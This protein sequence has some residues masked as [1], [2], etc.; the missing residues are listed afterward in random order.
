MLTRAEELKAEIAKKEVAIADA[1]LEIERKQ[2]AVS[3][4][5]A[6]QD[7][8]Y[9]LRMKLQIELQREE[10]RLVKPQPTSVKAGCFDI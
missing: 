7:N 5:R 10:A 9:T 2:K 8:L 6:H 1:E 3:A 4:L